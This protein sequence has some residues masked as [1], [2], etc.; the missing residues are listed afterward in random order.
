MNRTVFIGNSVFIPFFLIYIGMLVDVRAFFNGFETLILA[1]ALIIVALFSKY[2]A[3]FATKL[4]YRYNRE[5]QL[6]LFGLSSSHAAATIAVVIVG[7]HIGIF[8]ENIINGAVLII[9]FTCLVS[10]YVTDYAG[11]MVALQQK[12]QNIQEHKPDHILVPISNPETAM[13][14]FNFAVLIH[15]PYINSKV[16]PL[17][18]ATTPRQLEQSMLNDPALTEQFVNQANAAE[19]QYLPAMRVDSNISEGIIRAALEIQSTHIVLGWTGQSTTARYFFG[20]IIEKL[21]VNC[22]QTIMVMN[23]KSKM[24]MYRKIYVLIPRY[25]DHETGF[26]AWMLLLLTLQRNTS[27][28]LILIT[29]EDTRKG[30]SR[31]KETD[32]LPEMSFHILSEFPAMKSLANELSENDLLVI[33]SARQNTV[34]YSR[35]LA[36]MPRVVTRFFNHTN[37]MILYPEQMD[38]VPDNLSINFGV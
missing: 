2:L 15:Q 1:V 3:A 4:L 35:R 36:L 24:V 38:I 16:S 33:I 14:L 28:E 19:V 26:Q 5:E 6:L 22:P 7:Y 13:S 11:R 34:S 30:I 17:T 9:L 20:T 10:T 12:G 18:I 27:G 8:N 37:S 31:M 23:F 25:A 21:L 29:D 32:H